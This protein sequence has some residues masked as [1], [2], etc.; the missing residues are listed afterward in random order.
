MSRRPSTASSIDPAILIRRSPIEFEKDYTVP[1]PPPPGQHPAL[2]PPAARNASD[3]TGRKSSMSLDIP[4]PSSAATRQGSINIRPPSRNHPALT[5]ARSIRQRVARARIPDP[6][7]P[8]P[9]PAAPQIETQPL[10][11]IWTVAHDR[12]ICVLDARNYT[13]EQSIRKLRRAFPELMGCFLS[14]FMVERRLQVLDQNPEIDYFRVGLDFKSAKNKNSP[15][16]IDSR[17]QARS[18][19]R[20]SSTTSTGSPTSA[21]SDI[22]EA[23]SSSS[24]TIPIYR[25]SKTGRRK[26]GTVLGLASETSLGKGSRPMSIIDER[27]GSVLSSEG[28]T[29]LPVRDRDRAM[30]QQRM[31]HLD[32]FKTTTDGKENGHSNMEGPE[33]TTERKVTGLRKLAER[34]HKRVVSG[35]KTKP[36]QGMVAGR[37]SLSKSREPRPSG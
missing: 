4:R 9:T 13:T 27:P 6:R 17:P 24:S 31:I 25:T 15:S 28:I 21:R 18:A 5:A 22:S 36:G 11:V 14:P 3:G 26:A 35:T 7:R 32:L 37:R 8:F 20:L 33:R 2:R 29:A 30:D 16:T 12:A 34:G 1:A 23:S 10:P 19:E